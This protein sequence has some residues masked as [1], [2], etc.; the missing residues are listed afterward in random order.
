MPLGTGDEMKKPSMVSRRRWWDSRMGFAYCE[1]LLDRCLH[2]F[3]NEALELGCRES[4]VISM[5]DVG[6]NDNSCISPS[7][8]WRWTLLSMTDLEIRPVNVIRE[9]LWWRAAPL[10]LKLIPSLFPAIILDDQ[11]TRSVRYLSHIRI[12]R[13]PPDGAKKGPF[14][15]NWYGMTCF[16]ADHQFV[17]FLLQPSTTVW[18]CQ[19]PCCF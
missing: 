11:S 10:N 9:S 1:L 17:L 2:S 12:W 7:C 19:R 16:L 14:P 3:W 6:Y 13:S 8:S 5:S 18:F 15:L 4:I